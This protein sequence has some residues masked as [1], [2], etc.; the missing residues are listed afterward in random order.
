M[1]FLLTLLLTSLPLFAIVSIKPLDVGEKPAGFSGEFIFSLSNNRGNTDTDATDTGL[2]LQY[3]RNS[4]LLFFKASY[5]YGESQGVTNIDKSFGHIR[6]IH[7]LSGHWD[8]EL[9]LQQQQNAFQSL[10]GRTLGGAGLRLNGGDPKTTGRAYLGVGAFHVIERVENISKEHFERANIYLSYKY[11]PKKDT[12]V[13]LVT[14]YQPRLDDSSDY[15]QLSTMQIDLKVT[16]NISFK[17]SFD[18]TYD[19]KPALGVGTYDY[20]QTTALKYKF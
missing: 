16:E 6:H 4:S 12:T 5:Q 18:Y 11:T 14:Y 20:S 7:K 1:R 19:S 3:D 8:D 9:F 2:T 15:M 13:A 17:I 10:N